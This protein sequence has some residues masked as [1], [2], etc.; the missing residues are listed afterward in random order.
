MGTNTQESRLLWLGFCVFLSGILL[1][2]EL[3]RATGT[4]IRQAREAQGL[5]QL[6][7]AVR[8]D[9]DPN[10]VSRLERGLRP[11][12]LFTFLALAKALGIPAAK[13][14]AD[15]EVLQPEVSVSVAQDGYRD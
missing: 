6:E 7:L 13:L 11:P 14:M 10:T 4:V 2:V 9:L 5:S 12:S 3:A 15:L 8:C 1:L